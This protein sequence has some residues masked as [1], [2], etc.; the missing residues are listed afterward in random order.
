MEQEEHFVDENDDND[1]NILSS[2]SQPSVP[3]MLADAVKEHPIPPDLSFVS[4]VREVSVES[5]L[6]FARPF[7]DSSTAEDESSKRYVHPVTVVS[8][9][10]SCHRVLLMSSSSGK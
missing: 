2:H 4:R 6:E 1:D 3:S 5:L 9:L 10:F 7:F 8:L